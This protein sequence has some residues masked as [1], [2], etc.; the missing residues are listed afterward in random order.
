MDNRHRAEFADVMQAMA[1]VYDKTIAPPLLEIYWRVLQ[2][3]TLE[4]VKFA[5]TTHL[6]NP[7][8]GQFMPKPADVVKYLEGNTKTQAMRAWEK[9][10]GAFSAVPGGTYSTVCFDDPLINKTI[11]DMGGWPAMGRIGEDEL[12]FKIAEFERRYQSYVLKA[13]ARYPQKLFGVLDNE[14]IQNGFT[15]QEVQFVGDQQ[16]ARIVFQQGDAARLPVAVTSQ[17]IG[18]IA[19]DAMK[20]IAETA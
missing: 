20:R 16:K 5:L 1:V 4:E 13:P 18:A 6:S 11:E 9:V 12:P 17:G 15:A 19:A 2:H 3:Y 14:N 7:D 10:A 8:T